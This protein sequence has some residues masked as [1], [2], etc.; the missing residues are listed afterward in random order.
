M[1]AG[2]IRRLIGTTAALAVAAALLLPLEPPAVAAGPPAPTGPAAPS[3][4]INLSGVAD[5]STSWPFVDAFR[6]SRSWIS[7]QQGAAWGKGPA[8]DL[9]DRGWVR[10]LE[11]GTWAET[12]VLL[13]AAHMPKGRY[14]VTWEGD[15]D[16]G[17]WSGDNRTKPL[18]PTANRFEFDLGSSGV[19]L[20]LTRT[21]P[22]N[23]VRDIHLWMPGFE[24]TGA[25]QIFHPAFLDRLKGFR[26]LRFM[27]WIYTND[28]NRFDASSLAAGP[29]L[30][31]ATQTH[32]VAP[33]L[34]VELANRVGAD[35]WFNVPHLATDRYVREF[36]TLVR[37][38][39]SPGRK[40]YIE[41]SNETWNA[42]FPSAKYVQDEGVRLGLSTDRFQAGLRY[43]AQRAV[44]IF[45]IWRDVFGAEADTRLVRVLAAQSANPWTG[46]QVLA[47]NDAYKQADA[48]AIAP[49][50]HC[51][52]QYVAND[53]KYYAPGYPSVS[54]AV[55]A[56][57][58]NRLLANCQHDIDTSIREQITAYRLLAERYDVALVGY[59]GGQHLVGVYGAEND[60][61]L[62][63][64][65]HAANRDPRMR[66][67]YTS[68]YN[69]WANNGGGMMAAFSA[70]AAPGKWGAW[71]LL[72]YQDQPVANAPKFRATLD[73]MA[74]LRSRPVREVVSYVTGLSVRSAPK[75]GG[76]EI[77][78][79]G[80][81]LASARS[82][83][84]GGTLAKFRKAGDSGV[85]QLV[86][87]APA[88]APGVVDVVVS[89]P[90]GGSLTTSA[91]KFT[92]TAP[93]PAITRLSIT[94]IP[95]KG[96]TAVTVTGTS[97]TGTQSV[98]LGDTA[99]TSVQVLSD[100]RL[101]F[102]APAMSAGT[103]DVVVRTPYGT[104]TT[105]PGSRLTVG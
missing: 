12:P 37:D 55:K 105:S 89:G 35:A 104:S 13:E 6:T 15:G 31:S 68:Y 54:S 43:H 94:T 21:N 59:E 25:Q 103:V 64:L 74:E 75:Q 1:A 97:F 61:Q 28:P 99:A 2:R 70:T 45:E 69:V 16:I 4:G 58:R 52:G 65:F 36:A 3:I 100:T 40:A 23:Y 76:T 19:F 14:V 46:N 51:A 49:Y 41:Y 88:H 27:D 56:A 18:N 44:E 78:I 93:P 30:D 26:T 62:T 47:W 85:T 83:T 29:H 5:W 79:S 48:I 71:G 53:P 72:E 73:F 67:L 66:Q 95:V 92:Y 24:K 90:A 7:Q 10:R 81:R 86:A 38:T 20:R 9:D 96:G 101:R 77:V 91:T 39:L 84:F 98:M 80:N 17:L 42:Q 22:A 8:L 33:E 50:F 63:A 32:G 57:G 82:V 60:E 87:V 102:V 34:M 11:P